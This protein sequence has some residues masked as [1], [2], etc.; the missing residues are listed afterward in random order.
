MR[1]E[2]SPFSQ[3]KESKARL[4]IFQQA[5]K[6][7]REGKNKFEQQTNKQKPKNSKIH[8]KAIWTIMNCKKNQ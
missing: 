7:F 2:K 4:T 6:N 3:L 5:I 8:T 1:I